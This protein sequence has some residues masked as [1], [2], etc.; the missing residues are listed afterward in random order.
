MQS[1]VAGNYCLDVPAGNTANG[2]Q[3]QIWACQEGNL[4]Q[5]FD[6]DGNRFS[7]RLNGSQVIDA[8]GTNS[9]DPIVLWESH[10]GDNQKW[11]AGLHQV[12]ADPAHVKN[13]LLV[14]ERSKLNC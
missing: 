11:R 7:T 6:K 13:S 5:V 9:G 1:G 8:S 10:G 4:N 3:L 12:L 2:T 14:L